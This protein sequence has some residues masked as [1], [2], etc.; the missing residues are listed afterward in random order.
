MKRRNMKYDELFIIARRIRQIYDE[1][2]TDP[3]SLAT[4]RRIQPEGKHQME[5]KFFDLGV[6]NIR[7]Y[8]IN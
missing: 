8:S 6:K 2:T 4:G 5:S 1:P 3:R 7:T